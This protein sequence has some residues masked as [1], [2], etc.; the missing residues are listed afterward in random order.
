MHLYNQTCV[1]VVFSLTDLEMSRDDLL[2]ELHRQPNQSPTDK[3]VSNSAKSET[4][5]FISA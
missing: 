2:Q 5:V 1:V 4:D 3:N